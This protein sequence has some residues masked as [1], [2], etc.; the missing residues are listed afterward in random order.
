MTD[1][2]VPETKRKA[3]VRSRSGRIFLACL[4]AGALFGFQR[5]AF[6]GLTDPLALIGP[7]HPGW[8]I[9]F[10]T[11]NNWTV[12]FPAGWH[13][14]ANNSSKRTI[15]NAE[16]KGI[17][18]S[19]LRKHF[20]REDSHGWSP[21]FDLSGQPSN[22]VAVQVASIYS[23]GFV[24][25]SCPDSALP[26]TLRS[27]HRDHAN[28]GEHGTSVEHISRGF[29]IQGVP[30]YNVDAWVGQDASAHD[31]VLVNQIVESIHFVRS[32]NVAG[33][34]GIDQECSG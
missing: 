17:L 34:P 6:P 7:S 31:R 33:P 3:F 30:L 15:Y 24:V 1:S 11:Q 10:D 32:S 21:F 8:K 29:T 28:T 27:A 16:V 22:L 2:K 5:V 18:M 20:P 13:A 23:G 19:N 26:I 12:E 4:T 9:Y 25:T 14:Q